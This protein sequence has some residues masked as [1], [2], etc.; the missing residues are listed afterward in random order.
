MSVLEEL[1]AATRRVSEKAA[2]AAVAIGRDRRGTGVVIGPGQVLTNAHN[3][4]DRTTEVT[5]A[6]G[7]SVQG[8]TAGIDADG[9]LAVLT[10]DTADA[11]PSSGPTR[12]PESEM[13]SSRCRPVSGP[14][15]SPSASSAPSTGPFGAQAAAGSPGASSTPRRSPGD[16]PGVRSPTPKGV[17][18]GSTRIAS[19]KASTSPFQRTRGSKS[20]WPD[21]RPASH[22]S[23]AGSASPSRRRS[24]LP[25]SV[26]RSVCPRGKACWCEAWRTDLSR[27]AP[28]CARET[29]S[30]LLTVASFPLRTICSRSSTATRS[31]ST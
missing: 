26:V 14:A 11:P 21:S 31:R 30:S 28:G 27:T 17:C 6:D 9:D 1:S 15:G 13:P 10:V 16:P 2:G 7:R 20:V 25:V 4:R 5:F 22:P 19:G 18:S 12:C 8:V 29:S 23:G 24:S 3:L